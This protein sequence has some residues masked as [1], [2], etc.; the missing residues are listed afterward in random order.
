VLLAVTMMCGTA[1]LA[2]GDS[3]AQSAGGSTLT[4]AVSAQSNTLDPGLSGNGVGAIFDMFAYDSLV[5][6]GTDGKYHPDL[7]TSWKYNGT[8]A[9]SFSL[10]IRQHVKFADGQP[11]TPGSVVASLEYIKKTPG[12]VASSAFTN[13]TRI[14]VSGPDTVTIHTNVPNPEWPVLL[15]EQYLAGMVIA[16]RGLQHPKALGSQTYGAGEYTL[17]AAETV[18]NSV[19]TYLANPNYWDQSAVH[20]KKV[21]LRVIT[22]PTAALEAV[23]TGQVDFA[24]GDP[25]TAAQAKSAGLAVV[26]NSGAWNGVLFL[27]RSGQTMKA[28]GDVR[29]RQALEYAVDRPVLAKAIYGDY[30]SALVQP[31]LPG[32]NEYD[33]ALEK[34]YPY[35]RAKAK[36]LLTEAGYPQGFTFT[37]VV[38]SNVSESLRLAEAIA[39]EL[40][41]VGVTMN[42]KSDPTFSGFFTDMVSKDYGAGTIYLTPLDGYGSATEL[43]GPGAFLNPFDSTSNELQSLYKSATTAPSEAVPDI[44]W[45]RYETYLVKQAWAMPVLQFEQTCYYNRKAVTGVQVGVGAYIDPRDFRPAG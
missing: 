25:S 12:G 26:G 3:G 38:S 35:D 39:G 36:S 34:A 23:R 5:R 40:S 13:V 15:S 21:V 4:I 45:E 6:Y 24:V 33:P 9:E 37:D 19:Y 42:I 27:D 17:D 10:T 22:D 14:E 18:T 31:A 43:F 28:L 2:T 29:V 7:A 1:M 20:Y 16:P 8:Q 41:A 30:A 11:L 32:F 44:Y